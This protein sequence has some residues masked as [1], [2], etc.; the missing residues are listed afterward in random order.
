M[1]V[2]ITGFRQSAET[3]L[4]PLFAELGVALKLLVSR[5]FA[6]CTP[7]FDL[8]FCKPPTKLLTSHW[9]IHL[10][11]RVNQSMS[12]LFPCTYSTPACTLSLVYGPTERATTSKWRISAPNTS[13]FGPVYPPHHTLSNKTLFLH[14]FKWPRYVSSHPPPSPSAARIAQL[15]PIHLQS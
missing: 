11:T 3:F 12:T 7:V 13:A 14:S 2:P 5:L 15:C 1:R 6:I 9:L 8:L 4:S 10:P